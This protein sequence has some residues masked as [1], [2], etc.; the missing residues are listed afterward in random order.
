LVCEAFEGA[1]VR[2]NFTAF[3]WEMVV[4]LNKPVLIDTFTDYARKLMDTRLMRM[5]L[6]ALHTRLQTVFGPTDPKDDL[7]YVLYSAHDTQ[8]AN[9]LEFM[10]FT[11]FHYIAVPF[12]SQYY[13]EAFVDE[14]CQAKFGEDEIEQAMGECTRIHITF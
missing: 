3:E 11:D 2:Y 14:D 5:P 9:L 12:T 6:S 1:P 10:N 8:I 13:L 7:R 4:L